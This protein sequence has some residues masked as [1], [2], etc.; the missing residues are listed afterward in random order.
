[1]F[2]PG[3]PFQPCLMFA[4]KTRTN[5]SESTF[6]VLHHRVD[7]WPTHKHLIRLAKLAGNKHSSLLQKFIN[8]GQKSLITLGP[9]AYVIKRFYCCKFRNFHNMLECLSLASL[10]A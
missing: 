4:G 2:V 5:L 7:S 9:R 1:V 8:Y 3:K 10:P 6:Q